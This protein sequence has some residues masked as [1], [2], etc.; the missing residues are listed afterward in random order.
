MLFDAECIKV[1]PSSSVF[2]WA[3]SS[4]H[5]ILEENEQKYSA[6]LGVCGFWFS[7]GLQVKSCRLSTG[8][9]SFPLLSLLSLKA[10]KNDAKPPNFSSL[11]EL[12]CWALIKGRLRVVIFKLRA[13]KTNLFQFVCAGVSANLP[14]IDQ[15]QTEKTARSGNRRGWEVQGLILGSGTARDVLGMDGCSLDFSLWSQHW[16]SCQSSWRAAWF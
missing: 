11:Y 16:G 12:K 5:N 6:F 3:I 1:A 13:G 14:G 9:W 8:W 4:Q 15:M 2:W 7:P 10:F